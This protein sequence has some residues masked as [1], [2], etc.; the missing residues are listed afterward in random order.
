MC[1]CVCESP[2][3]NMYDGYESFPI[4]NLCYYVFFF[5]LLII[6]C[7]L[8]LVR[9]IFFFCGEFHWFLPIAAAAAAAVAPLCFYHNCTTKSDVEITIIIVKSTTAIVC[10]F[11]VDFCSEIINFFFALLFWLNKN[12]NFSNP[13]LFIIIIQNIGHHFIIFCTVN[14]HAV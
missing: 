10:F 2:A 3:E 6:I 1:V 11:L 12:W 5:L 9:S 8:L 4:F 13:I 14:Y 7:I